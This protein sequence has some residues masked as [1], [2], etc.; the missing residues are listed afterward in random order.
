[1]HR[2]GPSDRS[3]PCFNANHLWIQRVPRRAVVPVLSTPVM[4]QPVLVFR[5][6]H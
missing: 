1:M 4:H 3:D 5:T 2:V 6:R